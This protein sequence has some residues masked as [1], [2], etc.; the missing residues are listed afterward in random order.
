[1]PRTNTDNQFNIA[2][3]LAAAANSVLRVLASEAKLVAVTR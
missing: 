2:A 3:A 1:M